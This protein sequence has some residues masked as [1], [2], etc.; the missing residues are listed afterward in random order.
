MGSLHRVDFGSR[1][2]RTSILVPGVFL[3]FAAS[4]R[5]TT[6]QQ[7]G[8]CQTK[9]VRD[10][11]ASVSEL[12]GVYTLKADEGSKPDPSCMDGCVYVRNNEEYCFVQ[13]SIEEGATVVCEAATS[14]FFTGSSSSPMSPV[15]GGPTGSTGS[16]GSA[17]PTGPTGS[18]DGT[19]GSLDD[20]TSRV[21]EAHEK[22]KEAEAEIADAEE[23]KAAAEEVSTA[24]AGL[25]MNK[26]VANRLRR[27]D[28]SATT[29]YPTP[30]NCDTLK[31]TMVDL[32]NA[33]D[34]SSSEYSTA[35]ATA[36][37]AI[38]NKLT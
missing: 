19:T 1:R 36:I 3:L 4:W 12:N 16:A 17:G 14:P 23:A 5:P 20:L 6:A 27:Q 26:F 7:E 34:S 29:T 31:S 28:A 10:A 8:C 24:L 9:T 30:D 21:N 32:T 11:P 18:T 25:D 35:R 2:M 33:M 15:S 37:M 38:L 22:K 13:K